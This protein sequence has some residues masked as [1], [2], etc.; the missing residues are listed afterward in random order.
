MIENSLRF[1]EYRMALSIKG[2]IIF[3]DGAAYYVCPRCGVTLEREFVNYC[4]RCG[5]HLSWN[6]CEKARI[7]YANNLR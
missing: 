7:V 2:V 6:S 3:P 4:D 1:T 5:Q